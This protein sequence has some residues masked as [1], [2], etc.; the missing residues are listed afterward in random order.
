MGPT[1]RASGPLEGGGGAEI[2]AGI[3]LG[4]TAELPIE[5]IVERRL[6]RGTA[7]DAWAFLAA[8]GV[9]DRPLSSDLRLSLYGQAGIVG[10]TRRAAFVDGAAR[11]EHPLPLSPGADIRSGLTVAGGAQP[12]AAR[13]DLGPHVAFHPYIGGRPFRLAL[14][15]RQRVAGDAQPGSGP[16]ITFGADL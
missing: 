12:G 4:P 15:W 16:A 5:I 9:S 3:S 6:R 10:L 7:R 8:G 14:E 1:L 11:I 2:A 13:F